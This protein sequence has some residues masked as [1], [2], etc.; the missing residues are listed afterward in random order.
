MLTE[1]DVIWRLDWDGR[2]IFK[3]SHFICLENWSWL[4]A[5]GFCCSPCRSLHRAIECRYDT[6]ARFLHNMQFK[7]SRLNQQCLSRSSHRYNI[8]LLLPHSIVCTTNSGLM[9]EE[10]YRG[11]NTKKHDHHGLWDILEAGYHSKPYL[12]FHNPF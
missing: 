9:C 8:L 7:R 11:V 4:L 12:S 6:V 2:F 5:T 10:L 1:A 3:V